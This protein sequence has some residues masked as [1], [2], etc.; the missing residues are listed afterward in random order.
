MIEPTRDRS[1]LRS[2]ALGG[3]G[4]RHHGAG[5]VSLP[6][7]RLLHDPNPTLAAKWVGNV[8]TSVHEQPQILAVS[9]TSAL[10]ASMKR[11]STSSWSHALG[12]DISV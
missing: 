10:P 1:E 11:H 5:N 9:P 4:A 2:R 8:Y 6:G 12:A 7:W 3:S